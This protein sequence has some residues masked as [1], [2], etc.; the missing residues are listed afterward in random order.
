MAINTAVVVGRLAKDIELKQ[1]GDKSVVNFTIAVEKPYNKKNDHPEANWIDCVA[2]EKTAEFLAK[3]FSKGSKVGITG[4]LQT[5]TYEN[6][7]GTKIKVTEI[8]VSSVD[9]VGSKNSSSGQDAS[10]TESEKTEN[11]SEQVTP[12][13][14]DDVPF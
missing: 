12:L 8:L 11:K 13:D 3:Y 14:D 9:F 10:T 7:E 5:R 2:W 6:K 4:S 1:A